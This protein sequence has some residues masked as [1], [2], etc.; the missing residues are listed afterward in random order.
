MREANDNLTQIFGKTLIVH[1][2]NFMEIAFQKI[3]ARGDIIIKRSN[4]LSLRS[5]YSG[6]QEKKDSRR[7]QGKKEEFV[8]DSVVWFHS[9][10]VIYFFFFSKCYVLGHRRRHL[11]NLGVPRS[12]AIS[13]TFFGGRMMLSS[14]EKTSL[15]RTN[16]YM[17]TSQEYLCL[18]FWNSSFL[19]KLVNITQFLNRKWPG[20]TDA[21]T[22]MQI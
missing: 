2:S 19:L 6:C 14:S 1:G 17:Y 8:P 11:W 3:C 16:I 15:F 12:T 18:L 5:S 13:M 7:E 20:N 9:L 21:V 4:G 10:I 22:L